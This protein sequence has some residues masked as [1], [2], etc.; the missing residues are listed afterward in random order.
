MENKKLVMA[1]WNDM[2]SQKWN[3][4]YS[5]FEQN[6]II[7]WNNTNESFTVNEFV[8]ANSEY[9]GNWIITI[10]RLECIES[11]V[12]SVVKVQLSDGD[13]CFHATSFF[14]IKNE[15]IELLNEYWGDD[16]QAPQWRMDKHIGK[17]INP[18]KQL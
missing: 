8:I 18:A 16:G 17:P 7:N 11:L 9:P 13:A 15:K 4:L 14:E 10:K 6:A 5:Y 3:S 12:V 1:F 2:G